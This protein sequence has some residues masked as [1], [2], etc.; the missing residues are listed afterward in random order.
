MPKVDPRVDAYIAKSAEFARP[1]LTHLRALVHEACPDIEETIKWNMP[2]FTYKGL[3]CG[4]AAFKQ[5]AVFGF[6]KHD[7]VVGK[8]GEKEGMGQFG[9]ITTVKDLPTDKM[10]LGY[11]RKAVALNE[12]GAPARPRPSKPKVKPEIIVPDFFAAALKKNKTA[13]T[14][15][16]NFSYSHKK[17]YVQWLTEAK[18]P[19]TRDRR[20]QT[21]LAWI[22]EGKSQNWRYE[23]C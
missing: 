23:R 9:K 4:M 12:A 10:L 5:H 18:R 15:F 16:E 20:L 6:W 1:I 8:D 14:N 22:A 11:I 3:L 17:E 2:S 7:L 13:Q 21:A 19:E